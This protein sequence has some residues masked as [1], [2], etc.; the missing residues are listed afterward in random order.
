MEAVYLTSLDHGSLLPVFLCKSFPNLINKII[1]KYMYSNQMFHKAFT[2]YVYL[3]ENVYLNTDHG[4]IGSFRARE[5]SRGA[6][7]LLPL[8]HS[9]SVDS[10]SVLSLEGTPLFHC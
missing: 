3:V 6:V 5:G 10:C 8:L 4:M 2:M 7:S 1:R 9:Q